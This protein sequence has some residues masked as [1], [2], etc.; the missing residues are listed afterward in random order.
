MKPYK[1]QL[2]KIEIQLLKKILGVKNGTTTDIIYLEIMKPNIM[3]KIKDRQCK[4]FKKL[5]NLEPHEAVLIK[6]LNL[7]DHIPM[8]NYYKNFSDNNFT[9]Y[10]EQLKTRIMNSEQKMA[11]RYKEKI[12][13]DHCDF[14][15][16][17]TCSDYYRHIITR[18]RLS[19]HQLYINT[20][21]YQKPIIPHHQRLCSIFHE[22][23]DEEHVIFY[24][25]CYLHIRNNYSNLLRKKYSIKLLLHPSNENELLETAQFLY[26]IE[27]HQTK[28]YIH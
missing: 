14:L 2:L 3:S 16:N 10:L 11:I 20:G 1:K 5:R 27:R 23:E 17:S 15:Y 28:F 12:G 25:I 19:S 4:F 9:E 18:W 26:E 24:C 22:L 6:I 13:L 7:C 21:R 8:V